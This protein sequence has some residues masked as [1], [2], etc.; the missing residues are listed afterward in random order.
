MRHGSEPHRH[1]D[2][3]M[4]EAAASR[5]GRNYG[6]R[7]LQ[8]RVHRFADTQIHKSQ[9]VMV[10]VCVRV[11]TSNAERKSIGISGMCV[12]EGGVRTP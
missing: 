12:R 11:D 6:V 4:E 5:P 1:K 10:C 3:A 7:F 8:A 2:V 9:R